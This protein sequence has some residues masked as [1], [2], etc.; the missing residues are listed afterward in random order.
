MYEKKLASNFAKQILRNR[1]QQFV[2]Q[3]QMQN[4]L[5][6]W[7]WIASATFIVQNHCQSKGDV[8]QQTLQS[9]RR[10]PASPGKPTPPFTPRDA[11]RPGQDI[12]AA[13]SLIQ[14]PYSFEALKITVQSSPI[15]VMEAELQ[16]GNALLHYRNVWEGNQS[17]DLLIYV[18]DSER[19]R[20]RYEHV[21][22]HLKC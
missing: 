11:E 17:V 7:A 2:F 6:D 8:L 4:P 18:A 9:S 1:F 5:W 19:T 12:I 16:Q 15:E 3:L 21:L 14:L 22:T 13:F 10:S 20:L